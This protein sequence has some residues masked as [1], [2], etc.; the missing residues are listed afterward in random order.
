MPR[1]KPAIIRSGMLWKRIG[2]HSSSPR[3]N[4]VT[5]YHDFLNVLDAQRSV[6]ASQD[7]LVQS[8]QTVAT[9]LVALL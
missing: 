5:G 3:I 2:S 9:H 4:I 7:A 6:L 1:N 8:Q